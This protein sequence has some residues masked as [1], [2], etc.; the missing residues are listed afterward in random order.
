[1]PGEAGAPFLYWGARKSGWFGS[2]QIDHRSTLAPN[3]RATAVA[4]RP[5]C[6][7]LGRVM[8]SLRFFVAHSGPGPVS[9]SWSSMPRA[10]ADCTSRSSRPH[11]S[12]G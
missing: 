4:Q 10:S 3:R 12:S 8:P 2:F 9:V 5:Y 7:A 1:M 11:V 6:L